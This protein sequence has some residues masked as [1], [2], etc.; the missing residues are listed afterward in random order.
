M[1]FAFSSIAVD[2]CVS[3]ILLFLLCILSK[4]TKRV[5]ARGSRI[6]LAMACPFHN[7]MLKGVGS[8]VHGL[9]G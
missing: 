4:S 5:S 2:E 7:T 6:I 8:F 9:D 1:N 3:V